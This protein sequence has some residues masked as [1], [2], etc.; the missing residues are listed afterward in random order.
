MATSAANN[1]TTTLLGQAVSGTTVTGTKILP[2]GLTSGWFVFFGVAGGVLL[3]GTKVGPIV[4]G[5]LTVGLLYQIGQLI[6]GK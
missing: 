3:S 5:V 4:L 2:F 6:E 1:P